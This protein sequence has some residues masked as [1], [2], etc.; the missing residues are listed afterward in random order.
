M[1]GIIGAMQHEVE[2]LK[3]SISDYTEVTVAGILFY[4]G[5]IKGS[6]VV[7][8]QCGVGKVNA[9]MAT[10]IL[11]TSFGCTLIIN[12]GIAGGTNLVKTE[13]IVIGS[14]HIYSDFDVTVFGY[15]YGQVPGSS[16]FFIPNNDLVDKAKKALNKLGYDYKCGTIITGDQFV[17]SKEVYEKMNIDDIMACEMEGAA[18]AHAC[19][20]LNVPFLVLRYISDVIGAENQIGDYSQFEFKMAN[21]S[22]EICFALVENIVENI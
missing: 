4:K 14:R 16:E 22:S 20:K 3:N 5:K 6:D 12:T 19:T 10:T 21:R 15:K 2:N 11:A 7:I 9:A 18:I 17:S 8:T 1:I 13:D